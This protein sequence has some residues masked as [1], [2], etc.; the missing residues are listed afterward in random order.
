MELVRRTGVDGK[1]LGFNLCVAP[2]QDH[3][4]PNFGVTES[5]SSRRYSGVFWRRWRRQRRLEVRAEGCT[6]VDIQ[7]ILSYMI[8]FVYVSMGI[9]VSMKRK[10]N[11]TVYGA[12]QAL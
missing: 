12:Q 2:P 6:M 4:V 5:Q 8:V 9:N 11:K 7:L 3:I 1:G 10:D